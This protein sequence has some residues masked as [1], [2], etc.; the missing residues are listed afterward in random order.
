M[1]DTVTWSEQFAGG[2]GAADGVKQ[3]PGSEIVTAGNHAKHAV[4]TYLANHPTVDVRCADLSQTVPSDWPRTHA[5]WSSPEC[6]NHT[7]AQGKVRGHGE[8]VDGLFSTSGEDE[9]AIRSRAT[10]HCVPR[11]AEYHQ[12]QFIVVENVVEARWWGP[13][14]NEGA[15]FDVWLASMRVWGYKHRVLY[16]NSA[17]LAAYGP[18]ASC[19]RDR[20]YVVFWH[21]SLGRDPDFDK[22][23]RPLVRCERHGV[24]QA[25]QAFKW[26]KKCTPFKPWGKHGAAGQ[27]EWRCPDHR[28]AT[29]ALLPIA[30]RPGADAIDHSQPGRIIGDIERRWSS[31]DTRR[32]VLDGHRAYSGAPFIAELRGGGSTHR[33]VTDPLSTITAGGNHHLWVHGDAVDISDRYA[34]MLTVDER[35][36]AMAF[37]AGYKLVATAEKLRDREKQLRSLVG[38]AVTPNASRDLGAMAAETITGEDVEPVGLSLAA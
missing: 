35:K 11:F 31:A 16:L 8:F 4:A 13:R 1:P 15:A 2:G 20:M 23:T 29:V 12:Y 38:M 21:E 25:I 27:Y 17:H 14:N 24:V 26:T 3:V 33:A 18:A 32:K 7:V 22:W 10:M 9:T 6:T 28:C 5:L 30:R 34:R 19:S 37:P 36:V